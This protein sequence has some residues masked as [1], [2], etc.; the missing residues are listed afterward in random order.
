MESH[1][2]PTG[3]RVKEVRGQETSCITLSTVM[4]CLQCNLFFR[5]CKKTSHKFSETDRNQWEWEWAI[6]QL[7]MIPHKYQEIPVIY[8]LSLFPTRASHASSASVY[9]LPLTMQIWYSAHK[10]CQWLTASVAD[11]SQWKPNTLKAHMCQCCWESRNFRE[12]M[13]INNF[14]LEVQ[15][16][17]SL[18][19]PGVLQIFSTLALIQNQVQIPMSCF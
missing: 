10:T 1:L 19:I 7:W 3:Q 18:I 15:S 16:D 9:L 11:V 6:K 8:Q 2:K 12:T 14:E 4:H 5:L 13:N 17:K